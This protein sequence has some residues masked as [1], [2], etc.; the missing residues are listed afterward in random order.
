MRQETAFSTCILCHDAPCSK[1]CGKCDPARI[2]RALRF[3]NIEAAAAMLPDDYDRSWVEEAEKACPVH[4]EIGDVLDALKK[5]KAEL[6]GF[7]GAEDI[8]LSCDLCGVRLEN[9]FLLSSSVVASNYEMCARA[10]EMGW[11]GVSFKTICLMDRDGASPRLSVVRSQ[12]G[13]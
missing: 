5:R 10:F 12:Q 9:P 2:I 1:V 7:E 3:D 4:V 13:D 6:E 8:D 11:A